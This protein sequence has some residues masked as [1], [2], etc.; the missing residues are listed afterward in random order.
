MNNST[1]YRTRLTGQNSSPELIK[2]Q[3]HTKKHHQ[4][5]TISFVIHKQGN[6]RHLD[7]APLQIIRNDKHRN[8]T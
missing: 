6:P 3:N 4:A 8:L 2:L 7:L 1:N 5:N